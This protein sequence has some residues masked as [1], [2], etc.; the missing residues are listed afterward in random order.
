MPIK[1]N[2]TLNAGETNHD[3]E[4]PQTPTSRSRTTGN[5]YHFLSGVVQG[6]HPYPKEF[7]LRATTQSNPLDSNT[8]LKKC[9]K[10]FSTCQGA[11]LASTN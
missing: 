3:Q 6:W 1:S 10:S 4:K 7:L 2:F 11:R 8:H 9:Q 5:Q